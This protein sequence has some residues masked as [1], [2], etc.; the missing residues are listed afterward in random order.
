[1][2]TKY[3]CNTKSTELPCGHLA[4]I[5][6]MDMRNLISDNNYSRIIRQVEGE[7]WA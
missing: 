7:R 5:A 1:M 6:Y 4:L 2:C 3:V